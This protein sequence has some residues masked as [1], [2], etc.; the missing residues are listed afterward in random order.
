VTGVR[1]EEAL[2]A[3]STTTEPGPLETNDMLVVTIR[4]PTRDPAQLAVR[5]EDGIVRVDGPDGF[6]RD[7]P[8]PA[9][10]DADRLHAGLFQDV[11]ELRAPR[12]DS[13]R[14]SPAR[15]VTVSRLT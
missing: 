6:G 9:G 1:S 3:M 8:L 15:V 4:V 11:L 5:F 12:A 13:A 7:V 2:F 14:S 10:A